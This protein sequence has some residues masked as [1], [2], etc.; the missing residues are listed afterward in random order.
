[1]WPNPQKTADL[2]TFTEEIL[3][4]KLHF[5]SSVYTL[6]LFW[7]FCWKSLIPVWLFYC[8]STSCIALWALLKGLPNLF[9]KICLS[10]IL[11]CPDTH[12]CCKDA[13]YSTEFK[14]DIRS[15]II[16]NKKTSFCESLLSEFVFANQWKSLNN[17]F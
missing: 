4:A 17:T 5:F 12:K 1:M 14:L 10:Q 13:S 3:N 7:D 6:L 9:V 8:V 16:A 2:V 11:I 15:M